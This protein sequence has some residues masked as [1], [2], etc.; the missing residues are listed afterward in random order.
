MLNGENP[1]EDGRFSFEIKRSPVSLQAKP[2]RKSE[3]KE[4][5]VEQLKSVSFLLS[6]DV[7]VSIEWYTHEQKRYETS[8]SADIDNIIKPLLDALCG[9]NGIMIDDNQVQSICCNWF[10]Y[11]DTENEKIIVKVE[12]SPSDFVLKEGLF[13][14]NVHQH[15]YMPLWESLDKKAQQLMVDSFVK[16]LKIREEMVAAGID[17]YQGKAVMSVQRVFHKGRLDGFVLKDKSELGK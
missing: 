17:Y 7:K 5:V 6:G 3:F 16:M 8:A 4:F 15:L 1:S 10:D 12:F 13:F 11:D 9:P 2:D 14:I